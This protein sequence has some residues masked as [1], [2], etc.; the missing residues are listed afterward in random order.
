[1]NDDEALSELLFDLH[2]IIHEIHF[3]NQ[4]SFLA[5]RKLW[6]ESQ[7]KVEEEVNWIKEGF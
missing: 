7:L 1:M 4:Y 5:T 3:K 2:V 6:L